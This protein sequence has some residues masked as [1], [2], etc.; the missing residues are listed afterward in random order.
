M[1]VAHFNRIFQYLLHKILLLLTKTKLESPS[2]TKN[3]KDTCFMCDNQGPYIDVTKKK[4]TEDQKI[5]KRF[6]KPIYIRIC[7]KM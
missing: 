3:Q 6:Q 1:F 4:C 5:T 2:L 7:L